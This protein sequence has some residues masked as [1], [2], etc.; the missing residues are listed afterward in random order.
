MDIYQKIKRL[1]LPKGKYVVCTGSAME[2]YGIRKGGDI[3]IAATKDVYQELINRGWQEIIEPSGF[4]GLRKDN[5]EVAV[6]FNCGG[7]SNTTKHLIETASVINEI[8]FMSL[9]EMIKF[10]NTRCSKKDKNDIKLIEK[11]LKSQ[12]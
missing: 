9:E 3:D 11:Y 6:N 12:T 8:L 5:C 4:K 10:K 2:G 1:K 7:Y